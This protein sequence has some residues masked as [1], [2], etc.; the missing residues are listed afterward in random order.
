MIMCGPEARLS[1]ETALLACYFELS[2]LLV[3]W[4]GCLH[5]ASSQAG[6][7]WNMRIDTSYDSSKQAPSLMH[8]RQASHVRTLFDSAP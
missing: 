5:I 8:L 2:G 7:P 3:T 4:H 1:W 6:L